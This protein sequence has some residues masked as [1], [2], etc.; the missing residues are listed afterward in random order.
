MY[1]SA[2]SAHGC[3][4]RVPVLNAG[5]LVANPSRAP[6]PGI[7]NGRRFV[8]AAAAD[9]GPIRKPK[10]LLE[11]RQRHLAV[12]RQ[13]VRER[14]RRAPAHVTRTPQE[15]LVVRNASG[16]GVHRIDARSRRIAE[17]GDRGR[18]CASA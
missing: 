17:R 12:D 1:V 3:A 7:V 2:T 13:Q 4:G 16:R 10:R 6:V 14:R 5:R 18:D 9:R 11:R 15:G 8:T